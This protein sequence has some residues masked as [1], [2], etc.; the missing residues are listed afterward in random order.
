[1]FYILEFSSLRC[2]DGDA[3]V[4]SFHVQ[5]PWFAGH[6]QY[7]VEQ[8]VL[9]SLWWGEGLGGGDLIFSMNAQ[10]QM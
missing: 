3:F 4:H 2:C 5:H 1:M 10:E 7:C 9:D 8:R 6:E